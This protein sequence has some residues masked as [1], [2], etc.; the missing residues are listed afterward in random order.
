MTLFLMTMC[1]KYAKHQVI[2]V[3]ES[4]TLTC[5]VQSDNRNLL[6]HCQLR[7]VPPG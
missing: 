5:V 7:Q 1:P 4:L 6:L 2:N 3:G